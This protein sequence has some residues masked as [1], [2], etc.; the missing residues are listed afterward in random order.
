[1]RAGW[2]DDSASFILEQLPGLDLQPLCDARDVVD[3]HVPLRALYAAEIG[4]VNPTVIGKR[5]LA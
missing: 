5:L 3:R 4:P 1:M 2:G